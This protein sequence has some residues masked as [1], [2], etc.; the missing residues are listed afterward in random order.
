[1]RR[2]IIIA[3]IAAVVASTATLAP[4]V[5]PADSANTAKHMVRPSKDPF[6]RYDGAKPLRK[7]RRAP[8]EPR[9]DGR[10]RLNRTRSGRADPL[11]HQRHA[12]SRSRR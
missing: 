8:L 4:A 2:R 12:R 11:P 5:A 6:Y 7:S 9:G 3:G 1:M 10:P